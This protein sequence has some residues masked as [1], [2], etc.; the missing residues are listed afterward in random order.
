M[1]KVVAVDIRAERSAFCSKDV[2]RAA[3]ATDICEQVHEINLI[4]SEVQRT[5]SAS[6]C[7]GICNLTSKNCCPN[8]GLCLTKL[9]VLCFFPK[10]FIDFS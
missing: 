3:S 7:R 10:L 5:T 9:S 6:P 1:D 4:I 2:M 8:Q